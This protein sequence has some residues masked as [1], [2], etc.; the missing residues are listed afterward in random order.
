[1]IDTS[2][3]DHLLIDNSRLVISPVL[4]AVILISIFAWKGYFFIAC[5]IEYCIIIP[6]VDSAEFFGKMRIFREDEIVGLQL[7]TATLCD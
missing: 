4:S 7:K 5:S 1:V 3:L 2:P 6:K